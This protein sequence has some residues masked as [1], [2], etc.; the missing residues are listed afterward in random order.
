M[1]CTYEDSV[2]DCTDENGNLSAVDAARL[3]EDHS[4]LPSDAIGELGAVHWLN[5]EALLAW[6]GY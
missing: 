1:F 2:I 4:L 3:V 5:A 6:L